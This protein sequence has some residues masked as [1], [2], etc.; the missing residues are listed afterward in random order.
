MNNIILWVIVTGFFTLAFLILVLSGFVKKKRSLI[1]VAIVFL[2]AALLAGLQTGYT[3]ANK[4]YDRIKTV[5]IESPFKSRTGIEIYT[6]L[7]GPPVQNCVRVVNQTDQIVPRLDCCIWLEFKTCPAELNRLIALEQ[8]EKRTLLVNDTIT[9]LPNYSAKPEWF[10][11]GTLGDSIYVFQNYN[12]E[13]PS[14][15]QILIFSRDSSHAYYCDT[16]D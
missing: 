9:Y 12:S 3:V 1:Y 4:T 8:Y 14:R 16:A 7:F 13:N 11:P 15:S 2:F 5:E 6:A 10:Q